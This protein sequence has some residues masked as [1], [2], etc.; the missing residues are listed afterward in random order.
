MCPV[1]KFSFAR[2][3]FSPML[4][5]D[6]TETSPG[7]AAVSVSLN[8]SSHFEKFAFWLF[9]G[10]FVESLINTTHKTQHANIIEG[11]NSHLQCCGKFEKEGEK[12]NWRTCCQLRQL[13][14]S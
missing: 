11:N 8:F 12:A 14:I 9:F 3:W 1:K 4:R 10:E 13:L 5:F 2:V 6:Y 7:V